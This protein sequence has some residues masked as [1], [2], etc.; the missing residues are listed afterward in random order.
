[1][2]VVA[3][4]LGAL[5]AEES[6]KL[7][8]VTVNRAR[9]YLCPNGR[10]YPSVTNAI[11][12]MDK[13]ALVHWSGM[14]ERELCI[15]SAVS[16]IRDFRA[17]DLHEAPNPEAFGR[18]LTDRIGTKL[19]CYRKRDEAGDIGTLAHALIEYHLRRRLGFAGLSEPEVPNNAQGE[20]ALSAYLHFEEFA[21]R[22]DLEPVAM[23][24]A[25]WSER[26]FAGRL[27]L[28]ARVEGELSILDHKTGKDLYSEAYLQNAAYRMALNERL[29]A[30]GRS[31]RVTAGHLVLLPKAID[32]GQQFR[33]G[34][35]KDDTKAREAFLCALDLWSAM[36]RMKKNGRAA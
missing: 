27:D 35:I 20:A 14:V 9:R 36:E 19:A 33:V 18:L 10:L 7:E 6:A 13:P 30:L 32:A 3:Q 16:L 21:K 17:D 31:E 24:V 28:L 4:S 25:V 15:E 34:E 5:L 11:G 12:V 1:M 26:G 29:A 2:S 8:T 22:T 23:E